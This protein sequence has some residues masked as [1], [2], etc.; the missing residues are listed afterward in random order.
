[1]TILIPPGPEMAGFH[2]RSIDKAVA[3][4]LKTRPVAATVRDTL[5]WWPV[6]V[7]RRVRVTRELIEDARAKGEEPPQL[8]DPV[9]LRAGLA[10]EQESAIL[11]AWREHVETR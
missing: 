2:R 8:G 10:P 7:E 5:A 1:M 6:E 9:K 3:Q 11:T 4:G